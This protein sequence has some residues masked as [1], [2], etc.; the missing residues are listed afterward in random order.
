MRRVVRVWTVALLCVGWVCAQGWATTE[1]PTTETPT[2]FIR[3]TATQV[4]GI[5]KDPRLQD[6]AE[7]QEFIPHPVGVSHAAN[8]RRAVETRGVSPHESG[9]HNA[10]SFYREHGGIDPRHKRSGRRALV[11]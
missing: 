1:T 8:D 11:G 7:R 6:P 9:A 2:A 10:F 3:Q 4:L 5:L